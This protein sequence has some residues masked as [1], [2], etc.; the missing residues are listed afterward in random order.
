M[1]LIVRREEEAAPISDEEL[2]EAC[3]RGDR[4]ALGTLFDR[5]QKSLA[6][7][8]GRAFGRRDVEDLVQQTFIQVW[9]SADRFKK[10]SSVR[11][12]ILGIGA[13]LGRNHS[14][15]ANRRR[16][17]LA[18]YAST[19][20]TDAQTPERIAEHREKLMRLEAALETL[21][22]D[23]RVAFV[24]CEIEHVPGVEAAKVLGVRAGTIWRRLSEA[25][26]LLSSAIEEE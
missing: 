12:W 2:I 21:S 7:F 20:E 26:R 23:L 1:R 4:E 5:H 19:G 13:N 18:S 16:L 17:A 14:R 22:S 24:M 10:K 8:L 11:T 3:A 25:R 6:N 9:Q 15:T